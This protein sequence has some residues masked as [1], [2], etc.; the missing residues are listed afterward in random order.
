MAQRSIGPSDLR[1]D[2]LSQRARRVI[3]VATL[4]GL[5]CMYVWSAF[6][7]TTSVPNLIWGPISF[8]LIGLTAVGALVLY[9]FAQG[10]GDLSGRG[11]DERQQQ[12]RD[13]AW[14][15]SYGILSTVVVSIVAIVAVLVL[16]LDRQL[17]LDGATVSA[18]ALSVG[19]LIPILPVAAL[20]WLEP[21]APFDA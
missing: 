9:R 21:D 11:L 13:R 14:V 15:L 4:V 16:G 6:W 17:T 20:A 18:V 2:R 19:V 7:L 8:I 10:R 12:L 3:A 5:P 1:V